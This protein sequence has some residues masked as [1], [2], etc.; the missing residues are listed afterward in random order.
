MN[1]KYGFIFLVLGIIMFGLFGLYNYT[2]IFSNNTPNEKPE[3]KEEDI[4]YDYVKS[5]DIDDKTKISFPILSDLMID[6]YY[7]DDFYKYYKNNNDFSL[8]TGVINLD[9]SIDEYNSNEEN[10]YKGYESQ[11]MKVS[12]RSIECIYSCKST[13]IYNKDN[14]IYMDEIKVYHLLSSNE[15]FEL[16]FQQMNKKF[17]NNLIDEVINKIIITYDANYTSG[18]IVGDKLNINLRM[19][20]NKSLII[21]L[22][23]NKYEEVIKDI[24]TNRLTTIKEKNSDIELKLLIQYKR[25]N[26][27]IYNEIDE[28]YGQGD[29]KEINIDSYKAFEYTIN[30]EKSYAII[31]DDEVALLIQNK[32]GIIDINDFSDIVIKDI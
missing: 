28:F 9:G 27:S 20:K 24:N 14:S 30:N 31:I 11:G 16:T 29:K 26:V 19:S 32:Q 6:E 7:S 12:R 23:S 15:V 21:K 22:D 2:K 5:H 10:R 18:A 1:K 8:M 17:D 13:Q 4:K 3:K 25:D